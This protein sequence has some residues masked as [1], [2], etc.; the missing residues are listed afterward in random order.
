MA[1]CTRC[2]SD[3]PRGAAFCS[4]CGAPV[5]PTTTA[6]AAPTD[7]V[8]VPLSPA[9]T[10]AGHVLCQPASWQPGPDTAVIAVGTVKRQP[11]DP[12]PLAN[13]VYPAAVPPTGAPMDSGAADAQA[14]P[15]V[16]G[17]RRTRRRR[18]LMWGFIAV[19]AVLCAVVGMLVYPTVSGPPPATDVAVT[20]PVAKDP[21]RQVVLDGTAAYP[22]NVTAA[23]DG[24]VMFGSATK[25]GAPT[26]DVYLDYQC[27][28]CKVAEAQYGETM[29]SMAKAGD[30]KLIQHTMTFMDDN[31]KNH[32][33]TRAAVAA[34]CADTYGDKYAEMTTAIF[35]NQALTEVVGSVGYADTLMREDLPAQVRITGDALT[36]FQRCYDAEAPKAFL[37]TVAKNS[38]AAGVTGTPTFKR[39][40]VV[41]NVNADS[42]TIDQFRS[43]LL[44]GK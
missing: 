3:L 33:S 25:A 35:S 18:G 32:A 23:K 22:K 37:A 27:P 17:E 21:D 24:V 41:I 10:P 31:L 6:P 39:D 14:G 43:L 42:M 34:T 40:G 8:N 19:A 36:G 11:Q 38:Y 4:R 44:K 2:G 5:A 20:S 1:F 16:S 9:S 15:L 26:I 29:Y 28:I 13:G 12:L 30:I 7:N